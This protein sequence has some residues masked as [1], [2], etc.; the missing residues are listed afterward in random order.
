MSTK[1]ADKIK[2]MP[3][4]YRGTALEDFGKRN[5]ALSLIAQEYD[6]AIGEHKPFNSAHEGYAVIKEE[7]DELWDEIKKKAAKRDPKKLQEEAAQLGAMALRFIVDICMKDSVG[8][9]AKS[10]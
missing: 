10:R 1:R 6:R 8:Q 3:M 7:Y 4:T 5:T 9:R 2:R